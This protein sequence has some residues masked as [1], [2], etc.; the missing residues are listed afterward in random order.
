MNLNPYQAPAAVESSLGH[1]ACVATLRER[2][3]AHQQARWYSG[4]RLIRW[5]HAIVLL[6]TLFWG[7]LAVTQTS[8][9]RFG[10]LSGLA[11]LM[12]AAGVGLLLILL[13][14]VKWSVLPGGE[15]SFA[16]LVLLLQSVAM[17]AT[18]AFIVGTLNGRFVGGLFQLFGASAFATL[19]TSQAIIALLNRSWAVALRNRAAIHASELAVIGYAVC[20]TLCSANALHLFPRRGPLS[21]LFLAMFISGVVALAVQQF[22]YQ[23]NLRSSRLLRDS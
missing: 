8:G 9:L 10:T 6:S 2:F 18:G 3:N 17:L 14:V 19:L 23:S 15:R 13:G 16:L 4:L 11:I 20:A 21:T 7:A 1:E 12:S 22:A 5:G